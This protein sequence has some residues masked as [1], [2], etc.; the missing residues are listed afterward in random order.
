MKKRKPEQSITVESD[1]L[2]TATNPEGKTTVKNEFSFGRKKK[3]TKKRLILLIVLICAA[4]AAIYFL[5]RLFFTEEQRVALTG[6]T[7]YGSLSTA[8]EGSGT[9][10]AADSV[11]YSLPSTDAEVTGWYVEAGDTVE[12]GDLL[13]EQDDSSIDEKI[14]VLQSGNANSDGIIDYQT[15]ISEQED[16]IMDYESQLEDYYEALNNLIITAPFDGYL[17]YAADLEEG[18][19]VKGNTTLLAT[20]VNDTSMS[21]TEYF[22]YAYEEEIYIGMPATISVASQMLSLSGKVTDISYVERSSENGMKCFKVTIEFD[23]PGSLSEENSAAAVLIEEDG[24]KIYPTE[25]STDK[26]KLTYTD[27]VDIYAEADGELQLV[28]AEQYQRVKAGTKLF[29]I[30]S[31]SL[32]ETISKLE[33]KKAQAQKQIDKDNNWIESLEEQIADLEES[34]DD[35]KRYSEISGQVISAS[36][37]QMRNGMYTGSVTIYNMDTMSI[38]VS[39]D[40]LDIDYLTEGM[41]VNAYRTSANRPISY[42]AELTYLSLEATSS[43]EGVSTFEGTIT[44]NSNGEL[45]SGVTV[46]YSIDVGETTEGVLAP[47]NALKSTDDGAY[48]LIVQADKAPDNTIV[49]EDADYPE[50]Y[51]PISVEVGNSNESYIYIKSGVEA[52]ATVFLRYRNTAPSNGDK[53]SDYDDG[54]GQGNVVQFDFSTMPSFPGGRRE[55]YGG[56]SGGFTGGMGESGGSFGGQG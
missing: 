14:M 30:D 35:Y 21:L 52:D 27:S 18:D 56:M 41:K 25:F 24:T 9:S 8:I 17:I 48:Y 53:T 13:F 20:L 36:Y 12:A 29:Q 50:G 32:E 11:T 54:S 49:V 10:T 38:S 39:F 6:V 4:A 47:I 23:N 45:A 37:S 2:Q 31:T 43:D 44:I 42:D 15:D 7:S 19:N 1:G 3:L 16:L 28:S 40:E 46:Y 22:S 34:R 51:Y 5:Y 33:D 55:D 26:D